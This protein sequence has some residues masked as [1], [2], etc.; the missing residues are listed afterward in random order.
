MLRSRVIVIG[1]SVAAFGATAIAAEPVERLIYTRA[2]VVSATT[3]EVRLRR[4]YARQLELP[5]SDCKSGA[6]T[7][8]ARQYY[9]QIYSIEFAQEVVSRAADGKADLARRDR[10]RLIIA[11]SFPKEVETSFE[12]SLLARLGE[13]GG[14]EFERPSAGMQRGIAPL[15]QQ[16]FEKSTAPSW[17]CLASDGAYVA[18]LVVQKG[19]MQWSTSRSSRDAELPCRIVDGAVESEVPVSIRTMPEI[20]SQVRHE[21]R[22]TSASTFGSLTWANQLASIPLGATFNKSLQAD[23]HMTGSIR[24]RQADGFRGHEGRYGGIERVVRLP[25]ASLELTGAPMWVTRWTFDSTREQFGKR[26]DSE[27]EASASILVAVLPITDPLMDPLERARVTLS[28]PDERIMA[29]ALTKFT[30]SAEL[31]PALLSDTLADPEL[32]PARGDWLVVTCR[33]DGSARYGV[34]PFADA[35][36]VANPEDVCAA[37]QR[38]ID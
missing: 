17:V 4:A 8:N 9:G 31:L 15:D 37:I 30:Q 3:G 2:D 12:D 14:A 29:A 28:V 22:L 35:A 13:L 32:W 5:S 25:R 11:V 36:E 26:P 33:D 21:V 16:I 19:G 34:A 20:Q 27:R 24:E 10:G 7:C 18:D 1:L 23:K 38:A 6:F